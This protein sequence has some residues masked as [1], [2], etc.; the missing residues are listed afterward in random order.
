M[1]DPP[2]ET[3]PPQ[4][5]GP[6]PASSP[7]RERW[8]PLA[9]SAAAALLL[10]ALLAA[11]LVTHAGARPTAQTSVATSTATAL[12]LPT[13]TPTPSGPQWQP[14]ASYAQANG[15]V[16]A[17]SNPLV[18]YQFAIVS[19]SKFSG[20]LLFE[21]T[22]DVGATWQ[23]ITPPAAI[24]G[25]NS[26]DFA[27]P[28][29][30]AVSPLDPNTLYL[31]VTAQ[32]ASCQYC[33]V[34]YYS[35]NGGASWHVLSLPAGD[36]LTSL[37]AQGSRIWGMIGP[38]FTAQ[39]TTAPAGH[40]ARSD[41]GGVSWTLADNKLPSSVGIAL[42]APAAAG[43]S[44]LVVSD[45]ADRFNSGVCGGCL[46]PADYRVWRS[47]NAGASWTQVAALP[48]HD[49]NDYI[50]GLFVA[51][52]ASA[53][54]LD[55]YTPESRALTAMDSTD[56]GRTWSAA[57]ASGINPTTPQLNALWGVLADGSVVATYSPPGDPYGDTTR[58]F[59]AWKPGTAR[60]RALAAP[61]P[62]A[63]PLHLLVSAPAADGS[64]ILTLQ[65]QGPDSQPVATLVVT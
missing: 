59:Y 25:L 65:Y 62:L 3:R 35:R 2:G 50:S 53:L 18:G 29:S 49:V 23:D 38:P 16:L 55:V 33:T 27:M 4:L 60:W 42:Y 11:L 52:D 30:L 36:L 1:S 26:Q 13:A 58:A 20:S 34:Q 5:D 47:D 24:Q 28:T 12:T 10:I 40:L 15:L 48:Y 22:H 45:R 61:L 51:G 31:T 39:D 8:L 44:V 21:S 6:S 17:P 57:P 46:P 54:Y 43:H 32:T 64:Q 56:G 7:A 14:V 37:C 9:A 19:T 41:D 63:F